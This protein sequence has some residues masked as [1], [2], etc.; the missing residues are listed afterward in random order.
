[1]LTD[2]WEGLGVPQP[3][4]TEPELVL[5]S[6]AQSRPKEVSFGVF[7]AAKGAPREALICDVSYS[8][9]ERTL[10]TPRTQTLL[11]TLLISL[12]LYNRNK[13]SSFINAFPSNLTLAVL[14]HGLL[15]PLPHVDG[16]GINSRG[17]AVRLM[18]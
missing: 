17:V 8:P 14:L 6:P 2:F 9:Y 16:V 11:L 10:S 5:L 3:D 1:M 15:Y 18:R 13:Y 4:W 7:L 12:T